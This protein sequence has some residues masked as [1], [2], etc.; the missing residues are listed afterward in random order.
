MLKQQLRSMLRMVRGPTGVTKGLSRKAD[1]TIRWVRQRR[2]TYLSLERLASLARVVECVERKRVVGSF[3]EAGCALGGSSILMASLKSRT[4]PLA[5]YDVFD[6][7]PPPSEQDGDD[8]HQRYQTI[9]NGASRGIG[10]DE[11]YGYRSDLEAVVRKN[12]AEAG[13]PVERSGVQLFRGLLQ[14]TMQL[15]DPVAVAHIDVDWYQ[16]VQFAL[17]Q[18]VP[19][20][21]PDGVIIVDDYLDWSGARSAVDDYFLGK[22]GFQFNTDAGH[23][24]VRRSQ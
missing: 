7:I 9:I 19:Q 5:A 11:Y 2:L 24:V 23:L 4:R 16:P 21:A 3:I 10:G 17:S 22:S 20:L 1:R 12:F 15:R 13:L 18:I 14:E 8:V 6:M